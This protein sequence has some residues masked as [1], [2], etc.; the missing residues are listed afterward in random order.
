MTTLDELVNA[1]VEAIPL[2]LATR[3][4]LLEQERRQVAELAVAAV[5]R[6]LPENWEPVANLACT[7]LP[8]EMAPKARGRH[9]YTCPAHYVVDNL[10]ALAQL[11]DE[12][13]P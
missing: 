1:A 11:A 2:T 4:R 3:Y 5:L 7:C 12:V 9:H 10:S 8:D 6:A 13:K